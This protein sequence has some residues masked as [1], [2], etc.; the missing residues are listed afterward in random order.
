VDAEDRIYVPVSPAAPSGLLGLELG[1]GRWRARAIGEGDPLH[2]TMIVFGRRADGESGE[3][4]DFLVPTGP[5]PFVDVA[6]GCD[7]GEA[8]FF[9]VEFERLP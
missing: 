9:A 6:V 8:R 4:L 5:P 3:P 1:S 7:A 2:L